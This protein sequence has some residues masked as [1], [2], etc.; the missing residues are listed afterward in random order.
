MLVVW[1]IV[2]PFYTPLFAVVAFNWEDE[3]FP[4]IA[5]IMTEK[6][7]TGFFLPGYQCY[8]LRQYFAGVTV[9]KLQFFSSKA[10]ESTATI[11]PVKYR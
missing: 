3:E 10:A 2:L 7:V 5:S 9:E 1:A 4:D 6:R 11:F 8:K